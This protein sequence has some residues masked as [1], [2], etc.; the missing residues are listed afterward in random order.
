MQG[1]G[2]EIDHDILTAKKARYEL[3][4]KVLQARFERLIGFE[5]N[6]KSAPDIRHLL[7]THFNL[8][9]KKKTA[10]GGGAS[11]DE[12]TLRILAYTSSYAPVLKGVLD[13]RERRTML[14]GFMQLESATDGR[15]RAPYLIHGTDSGRA[16]LVGPLR[17]SMAVDAYS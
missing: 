5:C 9:V 2:L 15:Y 16:Y 10:K 3:E 12:E 8:P 13:I 17:I 6:V 4:T 14:S 7:Y 11:T 1:R